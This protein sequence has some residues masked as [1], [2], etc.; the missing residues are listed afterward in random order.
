MHL[1][2]VSLLLIMY[3]NHTPSTGPSTG[4]G[5]RSGHRVAV[6]VPAYNEE[7]LIGPGM[8]F[9]PGMSSIPVI[10]TMSE[11][12][13]HIVAVEDASKDDTI[14]AVNQYLPKMSDRLHLITGRSRPR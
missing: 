3:Q 7:K 11:Y 8:S 9:I 4:S 5:R 2:V 6:V 1:F 12:V 10:E 13:D 14:R